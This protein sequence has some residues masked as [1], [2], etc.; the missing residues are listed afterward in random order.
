MILSKKKINTYFNK[1]VFLKPHFC[2]YSYTFSSLIFDDFSLVSLMA[3]YYVAPSLM[4]QNTQKCRDH[5]TSFWVRVP[6]V[7]LSTNWSQWILFH[8]KNFIYL[9]LRQTF[10]KIYS[11]LSI[12]I[13]YYIPKASQYCITEYIEETNNNQNF[14]DNLSRNVINLRIYFSF[15]LQR[16]NIICGSKA[17]IY[18]AQ[19]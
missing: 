16:R 9:F 14:V 18:Y 13:N 7:T 12:T 1:D 15:Y 17:G 19:Q 3:M 2:I 6:I 11:T 8:S 10:L 4:V 5:K